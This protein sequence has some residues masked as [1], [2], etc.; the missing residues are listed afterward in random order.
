MLLQG[1][2]SGR[3]DVMGGPGEGLEGGPYSSS[4]LPDIISHRSTPNSSRMD[5][6][7]SSGRGFTVGAKG[8]VQH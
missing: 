2:A 7:T 3:Y 6:T 4:L 8:Q 5:T 1:A